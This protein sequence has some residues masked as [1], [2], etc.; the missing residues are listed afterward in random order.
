MQDAAV[1]APLRRADALSPCLSPP[2]AATANPGGISFDLT[3]PDVLPDTLAPPGTGLYRVELTDSAGRRWAIFAPDPSDAAGPDVVVHVPDLAGIFPLAPGDLSARISA[4]S[5]P[6]LDLSQFL[7]SDI[8]RE[9]DL[10]VHS[11]GQ[12]FTPP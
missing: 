8:E 10:F 2:G 4:W 9:H 7:W 11:I 6:G 12:T 5:W 1:L 3:F